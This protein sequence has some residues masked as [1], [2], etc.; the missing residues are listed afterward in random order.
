MWPFQ[1]LVF[2]IAWAVLSWRYKIVVKNGEALEDLS[3]AAICP[4]HAALIDPAILLKTVWPKTKARPVVYSGQYK[5][6][7]PLMQLAR[8]LPLDSTSDGGG[9]WQKR[10]MDRQTEA[11]RQ[12]RMSG[13]N[14]VI[15]PAGQIRRGEKEEIVGKTAVYE[16]LM[17]D[18]AMPII[19]A[20]IR[21]L[22]GSIF[23][24]YHT[25]GVAAPTWGHVGA[26]AKKH[27]WTFLNPFKRR[28]ITL[29]F[30]QVTVPA[31]SLFTVD[32]FNQ[33]LEKWYNAVP[34]PLIPGRDDP[35]FAAEGY[36]YVTG[37]ADTSIVIDAGMQ[38]RVV[39]L[40]RSE[41]SL[42]R[43]VELSLDDRLQAD[44]GIDSM[45][46]ATLPLIVEDSFGVSVAEE[47]QLVTVRDVVAAAQGDMSE[48]GVTE[49]EIK[50]PDGWGESGRPAPMYPSDATTLVEAYLKTRD[51]VG[52]D[53]VAMGGTNGAGVD[54][55]RTYNEK[56]ARARLI[57]DHV[58]KM[59][60]P[61]IGVMLPATVA[62][63][64]LML[65]CMLS[66]KTV[67][68]FNWTV[69]A[70]ALDQAVTTSEVDVIISADAFLDKVQ[71]ELSDQ[72]MDKIVSLEDML[73]GS[74]MKKLNSAMALVKYRRFAKKS[75]ADII[76]QY[77]CAMTH[78]QDDAVILFT[79]GSE[80]AP[81]GVPLT[82]E[83]VLACIRGAIEAMGGES[84]DVM[85]AFLPPFH[86]FG[87]TMEMMLGGA[88]GLKMVYAPDPKQYR[89]LAIDIK[90]W[91]ATLVPGTPDFIAGILS[92]SED[93]ADFATVR[94][95]LSGAQKAPDTLKAQVADLGADFFEGYGITET[96]PLACMTC[97]GEV[98]VGVGRPIRGVKIA[99]VAIEPD[100]D[101]IHQRVP[102]GEEGLILIAG[103]NVFSGYRGI[104]K[105]PFV[106][107]DQVRYYNTGDLGF[108][109]TAG[110][111]TISGRLKRFIK[112]NG[113]MISLPA[114]E[115]AL[116]AKWPSTEDGPV[117]A[118][119]GVEG[120]DGGPGV[121][122]LYTTD[123]HITLEDAQR[124]LRAA[125]ISGMG[126]P[127]YLKVVEEIPLLG[128]GKVNYRD[129]PTPQAVALESQTV[130]AE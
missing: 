74:V 51:R 35:A 47:S 122:C 23:S 5:K 113:E 89:R 85:L 83:N 118:V 127:R 75:T 1:W 50:A 125:G 112:V 19:L 60:G 49:T 43:S 81:K 48:A 20:R 69:G 45:S 57:A 46:T 111:L 25:G 103:Q 15:Y 102:D 97:P 66:G 105:D 77:P 42:D 109:D 16:M 11:Y 12:A 104:D 54:E 93:P 61:N 40:L 126:W 28:T 55:I 63:D 80:S 128:T 58:Q 41:F 32:A 6:L 116:T 4:D 96:A 17:Q 13:D 98:P 106:L 21:G 33:Y 92:V 8:A 99:I 123:V 62:A 37:G 24:C 30:D 56:L 82:H 91:Q 27:K 70:K 9:S 22:H 120:E 7:K 114:T 79:S 78:P 65:A 101:G 108:L 3:G 100:M 68:P 76:V 87:F 14:I 117:V 72:M 59:P 107:L 29:E 67:V 95:F 39:K 88:T 73:A 44:L 90:K 31:M 71:V 86:S 2:T 130:A 64:V 124:E 94:A 26:L 110:N 121:I 53:A 34:D 36:G 84:S 10:R 38:E 129:L 52:G 18:P 115:D 119:E